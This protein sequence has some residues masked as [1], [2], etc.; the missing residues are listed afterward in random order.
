MNDVDGDRGYVNRFGGCLQWW[1]GRPFYERANQTSSSP[2]ATWRL[3]TGPVH[4][5][6]P[7]CVQLR[8]CA[9]GRTCERDARR[10]HAIA[11]ARICVRAGLQPPRAGDRA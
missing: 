5:C 8:A 9:L 3:C 7:F 1:L 4:Q 2:E 10:T 6:W 11:R